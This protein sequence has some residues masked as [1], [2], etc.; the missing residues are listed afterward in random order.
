MKIKKGQAG[1]LSARKKS[2]QVQV[3][4]GFGIVGALLLMGY[5]KTHS[6]T[7]LFT[8]LAVLGC[9]PSAKALTEW[10]AVLP[11]PTVD[12]KLMEEIRE[13][14]SLFTT[15]YDLVITSREKIMPVDAIVISNHT[16]FGYAHNPKTDTE[17]AA[18]HIKNILAENH[19]TKVTVKIF[20]EYVPFLS[21]VEGLNN[22]IEVDHS[23]DK[24]LEEAIRQIILNIS[25]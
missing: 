4:L 6:R 23:A 18:K 8:V 24:E 11:Y 9:L 15:A 13:K 3:L 16:V 7:S 21:R 1:Y 20:S 22:M 14:S 5:L 19:Y 12:V 17:T 10:I 25:M 2:L